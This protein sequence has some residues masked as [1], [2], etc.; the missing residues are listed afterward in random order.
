M[1]LIEEG[2]ELSKITTLGVGGPARFFSK[3]SSYEDLRLSVLFANE[4]GV[5]FKVIG[6]GSNILVS[7]LGFDGLIIKMDIRGTEW[8]ESGSKGEMVFKVS[9]GERWDSV[10]ESSVKRG[11]YGIENLSGIPGTAGAAPV[12]NIGS[13]GVELSDVLISVLA[14]DTFEDRTVTFSKRDCLFGYRESV[15]KNSADRF[16]IIS[17]EMELSELTGP[18]LEYKDLAERMENIKGRPS[19][20]DVR[21]S[22]LEIRREKFSEYFK[23]LG[24]AG[25]F[26]KNLTVSREETKR[27]RIDF[28]D[29]PFHDQS[30]GS[31]KIPL[32]WILD[33]VLNLRGYRKGNVGLS[34]H[35]PLILMSFSGA[36]ASEI[37]SFADEIAVKVKNVTGLDIE[38]EVVSVP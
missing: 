13:Y 31:F 12:Q 3:V 32:A 29:I 10:V 14:Y 9:A 21:D 24:S 28:P 7:D 15:F 5:P 25:S 19:P 11:L 23:G 26:F 18:R 2:T 4:R 22:L 33:R 37:D 34:E 27:L 6:G 8:K 1:F 36:T 16:V 17:L 30:D 38:R 35:Q 20:K